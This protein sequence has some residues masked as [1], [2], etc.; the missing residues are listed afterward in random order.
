MTEADA[1]KYRKRATGMA[2][3]WGCTADESDDAAQEA[4]IEASKHPLLPEKEMNTLLKRAVARYIDGDAKLKQGE[5]FMADLG[6]PN[7][8]GGR[9][10]WDAPADEDPTVVEVNSF[11]DTLSKVEREIVLFRMEGLTMREIAPLVG[12]S[13]QGVDVVL[14][15]LQKLLVDR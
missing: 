11:L 5:A 15:R 4:M 12:M 14:H 13:H 3:R 2:R 6:R 8:D 9:D 7:E 10:E 1:R